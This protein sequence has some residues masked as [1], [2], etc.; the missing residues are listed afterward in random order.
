MKSVTLAMSVLLAVFGV[1]HAQGM[2]PDVVFER[3]VRDDDRGVRAVI[4]YR[5][6]VFFGGQDEIVNDDG[7]VSILF[8]DGFTGEFTAEVIEGSLAEDDA[9]AFLREAVIAVCPSVE[10]TRLENEWVNIRPPYYSI[11]S[12]CPEV[13]DRLE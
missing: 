2:D 5:P 10:R 6:E 11:Y 12:Q 1:A 13:D 9:G 7:T 3:T 8:W 4:R